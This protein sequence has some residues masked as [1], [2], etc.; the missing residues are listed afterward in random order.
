MAKH[1]LKPLAFIQ[2]K[3]VKKKEEKKIELSVNVHTTGNSNYKCIEKPL[4][5]LQESD[6]LCN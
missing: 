2:R 1:N 6:C 5:Q 3:Y 4:Q